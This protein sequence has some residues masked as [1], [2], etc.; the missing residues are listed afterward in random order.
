MLDCKDMKHGPD[1]LLDPSFFH[2]PS[3]RPIAA[4]TKLRSACSTCW[5][6]PFP[7]RNATFMYADVAMKGYVINKL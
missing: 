5:S 6:W 1:C 3:A 7:V 4:S 2:A